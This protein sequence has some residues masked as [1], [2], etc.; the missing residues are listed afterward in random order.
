MASD[1]DRDKNAVGKPSRFDKMTES[2]R[3]HELRKLV[4]HTTADILRLR[5]NKDIG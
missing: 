3:A 5:G 4:A 1:C 2:Q